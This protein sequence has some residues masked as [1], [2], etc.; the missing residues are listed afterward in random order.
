[1]NYTSYS[2]TTKIN[3]GF[4]WKFS[5]STSLIDKVWSL[6][7]TALAD[8]YRFNWRIQECVRLCILSCSQNQ[9]RYMSHTSRFITLQMQ[10]DS[11]NYIVVIFTQCE[12]P[13]SFSSVS[14]PTILPKYTLLRTSTSALKVC[15]AC[16]SLRKT[17]KFADH[18]VFMDRVSPNIFP[19]HWVSKISRWLT[20][21]NLC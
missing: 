14:V 3:F 15:G 1:M 2:V 21:L 12:D 19:I 9:V 4:I 7:M 16:L 17:G 18:V 8:V 6:V 20:H 5:V 13:V 11:S 10:I